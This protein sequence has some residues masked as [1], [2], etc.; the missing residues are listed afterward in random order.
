[1]AIMVT[2]GAGYIGAHVVRLLQERGDEVIVVDD[3]SS[4]V[5]ENVGESRLVEMNLAAAD[6]PAALA[7]LMRETGTTAV[8]HFGALKQVGESVEQP[9]RYYDTNIGGFSNL[10]AAMQT[11]GVD[12]LVFSSSAATYGILDVEYL[13]EDLITRPTSPYGETKLINEWMMQAQ[14][15]AAGLK[16]VALRYFNVAGAGWD[17]LGDR[18]TLN[19]IPL[20]L[21]A[22][23][24][25]KDAQIFG[26]DY[27][28]PDGTCQ[29]DYVHVLDLAEAHLAALEYLGRDELPYDVFNVGTGTGTS[30]KQIISEIE[31]VKGVDTN[32]QIQPRRGGDPDRLVCSPERIEKTLGWKA[33]RTLAES[34]ESAVS[35]WTPRD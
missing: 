35:A 9:L 4:G 1:M 32:A 26:D 25:G 11:A 7:E 27:N 3:L 8:V 33:T 31:R 2:G 17:D 23:D 6:T 19:L 34:V 28:T 13:T 22:I 14:I 12:Q 5:R 15:K 21:R 24:H 29:R 16:G 18:A 10:L 30:V 20:V